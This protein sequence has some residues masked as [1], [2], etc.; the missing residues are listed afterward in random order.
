MLVTYESRQRF[1]DDPSDHRHGTAYGYNIGCRCDACREAGRERNRAARERAHEKRLEKARAARSK[2]KSDKAKRAA[3]KAKKDCDT[4]N[5]LYKPLMGKPSISNAEGICCWCG[6]PGATNHHHIVPRSAGNVVVNGRALSKPTVLLCGDGN[7]SGC[8]GKAHQ[9]L[10][11]FRWHDAYEE[12]R[13]DK[14]AVPHHD[15]GSGHIEGIE[16][17]EPMKYQK[18]LEIEEGWRRV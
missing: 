4:L 11:H 2:E 14:V 10:L 12:H 13:R 18:A 1:L 3:R 6:A 5:E 15:V 17:D 7:A 16:L 8:H 9:H